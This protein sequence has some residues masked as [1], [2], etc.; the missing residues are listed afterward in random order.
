MRTSFTSLALVLTIWFSGFT[1]FSV[2]A[3][4]SHWQNVAANYS[5]ITDLILQDDFSQLKLKT[6]DGRWIKMS[7][8][9]NLAC[10]SQEVKVSNQGYLYVLRQISCDKLELYVCIKYDDG[11]GDERHRY[12]F[13]PTKGGGK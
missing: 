2:F 7:L 3:T 1:T 5:H 9:D 12:T 13:V 8:D 11:E 6:A 4:D 10:Y